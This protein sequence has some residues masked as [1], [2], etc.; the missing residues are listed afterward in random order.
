MTAKRI[1]RREIVSETKQLAIRYGT[2]KIVSRRCEMCPE[3]SDMF[4]PEFV[5]E[6]FSISRREIYRRIEAN[7]VHFIEIDQ[8]Q[9]LVCA[10]SLM[11]GITAVQIEKEK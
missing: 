8:R 5:S 6:I 7:T 10:S 1:I 2:T 4:L 3:D 11:Q 9:I